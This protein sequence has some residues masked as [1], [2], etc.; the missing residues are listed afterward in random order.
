MTIKITII[1]KVSDISKYNTNIKENIKINNY[2]N[3]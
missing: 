2:N 1:I 3:N